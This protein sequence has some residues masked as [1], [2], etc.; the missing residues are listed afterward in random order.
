MPGE[1]LVP[2]N[3][4]KQPPKAERSRLQMLLDGDLKVEDLDD[5]EIQ[6]MQLRNKNGDFR[7][8][9]P[10][11]IPREMANA[12][13]IELRR[14][15]ASEMQQMLPLALKAHKTLLTSSLLMPGDAAKMA[16]VKETY[17]RTMGKVVQQSEVHAVVENRSFE[18]FVGD[19]VI[20]VEED[21]E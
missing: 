2:L 17:E 13:Q 21:D 11:W 7:G 16:A 18:D 20:D 10:V 4:R 15:F 5:E 9:P 8:R 3:R 14:R 12:I 19:A 6:R 1:R